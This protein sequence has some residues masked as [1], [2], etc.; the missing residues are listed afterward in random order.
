MTLPF[1][2]INDPPTD[3]DYNPSR[4]LLIYLCDTSV[5]KLS[6]TV[7][8]RQHDSV[9]CRKIGAAAFGANTC[10]LLFIVFASRWHPSLTGT[11]IV[12]KSSQKSVK[13]R[14]KEWLIAYLI[15]HTKS[16]M[17]TTMRRRPN[18]VWR[19]RRRQP[20]AWFQ[21]MLLVVISML[22][23]SSPSSYCFARIEGWNRPVFRRMEE[24]EAVPPYGDQWEILTHQDDND[25]TV[26]DPSTMVTSVAYDEGRD[27]VY[28][29]GNIGGYACWLGEWHL[30]SKE[31]RQQAFVS[32]SFEEGD[33]DIIQVCNDIMVSGES[34][35]VLS[36][37]SQGD[38]LYL[39]P[40]DAGNETNPL[41]VEGLV[42]ELQ[43]PGNNPLPT[44][45]PANSQAPEEASL[46]TNDMFTR[47]LRALVDLFSDPVEATTEDSPVMPDSVEVNDDNATIAP[48]E[49]NA[50]SMPS[51]QVSGNTT[52]LPTIS[53]SIL[54]NGTETYAPSP[55]QNN[56]TTAAPTLVPSTA[57][58]SDALPAATLSPTQTPTP[59]LIPEEG[60]D[61]TAFAIVDGNHLGRRTWF[62]A[63]I[64][65]DEEV[66]FIASLETAISA[67]SRSIAL[68]D[69][70]T[71]GVGYE[72][73]IGLSVK[74]RL[75]DT[76]QTDDAENPLWKNNIWKSSV[77][78]FGTDESIV[79]LGGVLVHNDAV[80]LGG[81][82]SADQ[83]SEVDGFVTRISKETGNLYGL[84]PGTEGLPSSNRISSGSG[85][86]DLVTDVCTGRR[87]WFFYITGSAKNKEGGTGTHAFLMKIRTVDLEPVWTVRFTAKQAE[88]P[89]VEGISCV[90][91]ADG[92]T[93]YFVG[94]VLNGGVVAEFN[95]T[96]AST[97]GT[98]IFV[99][100][101]DST[102]GEILSSH[103]FGSL[104]NDVVAPG[105]ALIALPNGDAAIVGNTLGDLFES[106]S[107]T[108]V[109]GYEGFVA[110]V[111]AD[112]SVPPTVLT[113]PPFTL[114]PTTGPSTSQPTIMNSTTIAPTTF[115]A[116]TIAPN[117]SQP[118]TFSPTTNASLSLSPS[119]L[120]PTTMN[121]TTI[122]PS[123]DQPK[124]LSP[125]TMSP[126][127]TVPSTSQPTT[128]SP[129]TIAPSTSLG[130]WLV[131][132]PEGEAADSQE[133]RLTTVRNAR[134]RLSRGM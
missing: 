95:T 58:P 78:P 70:S 17:A 36:H 4:L 12:G 9:Q 110:I 22:S 7:C 59:P 23:C 108:S 80:Y 35:L 111:K 1:R 117:A 86:D 47:T 38:G 74:A 81:S 30:P 71:I 76:T 61:D 99:A 14:Q 62:P 37:A 41:R 67:E 127:T 102:N 101:I 8:W 52:A 26:N 2:G 75:Y 3:F 54:G 56:E 84:D 130:A 25:D 118:T 93:V 106:H 82:I 31:L 64:D 105:K 65:H 16:W 69:L 6:P 45:S 116:S 18:P 24:A 123:T 79:G 103:Q 104:Q 85:W 29:L 83:T 72:E 32:P 42:L 100:N 121:T 134:Q 60:G 51:S 13:A 128:L 89:E 109:I 53:P 132:S 33:G 55:V 88:V 49:N 27:T 11:I 119:T 126:T 131:L 63:G 92:Q 44:A 66:M 114:S 20:D 125:T 39:D 91:A 46:P 98:D 50:T 96:T 87:S 5:L 19:R 68:R 115:N 73:K 112:G 94:N 40:S 97:G 34:L 57:A 122:T 28:M 43:R 90:A 21:P 129:T 113:P 15:T 133:E 120:A 48:T 107:S 124:T 10:A 77:D